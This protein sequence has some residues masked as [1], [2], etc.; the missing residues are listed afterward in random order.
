MSNFKFK[1]VTSLFLLNQAAKKEMSAEDKLAEKIRL[2]KVQE[3]ADLKNAEEL[4]GKCF[5]MLG[6]VN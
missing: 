2:Q 3:A 1:K 4:F 5:I 6:N